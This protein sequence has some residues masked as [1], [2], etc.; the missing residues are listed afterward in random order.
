MR[1]VWIILIWFATCTFAWSSTWQ[2][3]SQPIY[4]NQHSITLTQYAMIHFPH[5]QP[6]Q[7]LQRFNQVLFTG[8]SD[9]TGDP[10]LQRDLA[11]ALQW[12]RP[13][14]DSLP[15]HSF[16]EFALASP[17]LYLDTAHPEL[18]SEI[19]QALASVDAWEFAHLPI[20]PSKQPVWLSPTEAVLQMDSLTSDQRHYLQSLVQMQKAFRTNPQHDFQLAASTLP[21]PSWRNQAT[22]LVLLYPP[23]PWVPLLLLL[24]LFFAWLR[25]FNASQW[26]LIFSLILSIPEYVLALQNLT[27]FT[28][29]QITGS[30]ISIPWLILLT[31]LFAKPTYW[32]RLTLLA[33]AIPFTFLAHIT[34]FEKA[35]FPMTSQETT[36]YGYSSIAQIMLFLV[37]LHLL[38]RRSAGWWKDSESLKQQ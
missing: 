36:L 38:L 11:L 33:M 2:W 7:A 6:S 13:F 16:W 5:Q 18:L 25:K 10:E 23:L 31:M 8:I 12:A 37:L 15:W 34:L 28:L 29:M 32:Q 21:N 30:W 27:F 26:L 4:W 22:T 35:M 24:S 19:Q 1:F 20:I 17:Q 3:A 9:S 14:E